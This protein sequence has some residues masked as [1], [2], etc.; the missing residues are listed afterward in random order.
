MS[1]HTLYQKSILEHNRKPCNFGEMSEATHVARGLN[2][3]C[4]DDLK[5]YLHVEDEIIVKAGF[6]GD[7]CAISMASASMMCQFLEQKTTEQALAAFN[8]F[9]ALMNG[10]IEDSEL[11]GELS[12]MKLVRKTKPRIKSA[13]LCWHAMRAALAGIQQTTTEK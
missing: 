12:V 11:L 4:G 3:L 7:A 6:I 1:I 8:E 10:E 5:V 9:E 13:R 2:A